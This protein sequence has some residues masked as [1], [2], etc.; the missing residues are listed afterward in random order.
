MSDTEDDAEEDEVDD[1]E[2]DEDND[3]IDSPDPLHDPIDSSDLES[4]ATS[5][6]DEW[7]EEQW[8]SLSL[9]CGFVGATL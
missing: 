3:Y 2:D 5:E 6:E 7:N 4:S 1:E 8:L 9:Y